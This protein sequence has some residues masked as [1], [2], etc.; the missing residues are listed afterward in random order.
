MRLIFVKWV[1]IWL[2][3]NSESENDGKK[4]LRSKNNYN[5]SFKKKKRR[6]RTIEILCKFSYLL[7]SDRVGIPD[8]EKEWTLSLSFFTDL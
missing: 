1:R 7:F 8:L 5:Y 6:I 2:E 3:A 4:W